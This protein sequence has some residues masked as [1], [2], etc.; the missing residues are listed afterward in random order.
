[1]VEHPESAETRTATTA[2]LEN[3][4]QR[5]V[6]N[7]KEIIADRFDA[8]QAEIDRRFN[9]RLSAHDKAVDRI[10]ENLRAERDFAI[11]QIEVVTTRLNAMDEATSVL[12]ESVTRVPTDV[13]LQVG[14]LR[15]VM[16]ERFNSIE[17][18]FA[19]RDV[20]SEREARDNKVAVDAAFA[21]QKEAAA[22]QDESNAKAIDKSENATVETIRKLNDIVDALNKALSDKVDD[23]K[24]RIG[25][26]EAS[27]IGAGLNNQQ[28]QT[29]IGVVFGA[30]LIGIALY[31][32]LHK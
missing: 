24:A 3:R 18:Q 2:D 7:L 13:Q 25:A 28:Y 9:D 30:L 29:W 31:A 22:R 26:V 1:M 32:A 21:A 10:K 5:E 19:E 16:E 15:D 17:K 20:R 23:L 11:G 14:N 6:E 27:R 4:A 8:L 12:R